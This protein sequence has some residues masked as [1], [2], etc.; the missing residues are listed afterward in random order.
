MSRLPRHF[1]PV[2]A[3]SVQA[4]RG[5]SLVELLVVIAMI[6]IISGLLITSYGH[7]HREAMRR[8]VDQ[9]NA[10]EIVSLGVCATMGGADFVV[11][12]DKMATVENLIK[13]TV[14]KE[15]L[16]KGKT[17]RLTG[18]DRHRIPDALDFVR[19]EAGLL[20]YEPAGG[21]L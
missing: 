17:F 11:K 10:Q 6:G 8:M 13:G 19:F 4:R 16:W 2:F 1:R 12:D 15:G 18:L 14:G 7:G 20:L 3:A 9:R 5:F 21:Q